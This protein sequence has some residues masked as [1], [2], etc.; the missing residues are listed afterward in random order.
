MEAKNLG[1]VIK[2]AVIGTVAGLAFITAAAIGDGNKPIRPVNNKTPI[3]DVKMG[4]AY[5]GGPSVGMQE[6]VPGRS[7]IYDGQG[8]IA[9]MSTYDPTTGR[10]ETC[11]YGA[12]DKYICE[13][14]Q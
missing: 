11:V 7:I 9:G 1:S 13:S 12:E 6:V 4:S 3:T 5:N 2:G 10:S 8:D 14:G